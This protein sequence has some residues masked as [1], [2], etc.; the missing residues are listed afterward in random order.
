MAYVI[1]EPCIG[2]KDASCVDVCPVDCIH[3]TEEDQ[4]YYI[5]PETCID[6]AACE[7]VFPVKGTFRRS[8]RKSGVPSGRAPSASP[9]ADAPSAR[10]APA[11]GLLLSST[12]PE[13]DALSHKRGR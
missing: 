3:S 11:I 1:T 10:L 13:A 8:P 6:C 4:K 5:D 2:V 7:T 12:P 9:A